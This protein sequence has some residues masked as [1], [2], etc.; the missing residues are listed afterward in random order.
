VL[1]QNRSTPPEAAKNNSFNIAGAVGDDKAGYQ[2]EHGAILDLD[3]WSWITIPTLSSSDVEGRTV[4]AAGKDLFVFGGE[5]WN[6]SQGIVLDQSYLWRLT[7]ADSPASPLGETKRSGSLRWDAAVLEDEDQLLRVEFTGGP[8]GPLQEPCNT[9]YEIDVADTA[10]TVTLTVF[11]LVLAEPVEWPEGTGCDA[12]G[13]F[14]QL[15]AS[16]SEPLGQRTLIDGHDDTERVAIDESVLIRSVRRRR[17]S[18]FGDDQRG[19]RHRRRLPLCRSTHVKLP[20]GIR[21]IK[22]C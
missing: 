16:L 18:L 21:R 11:Q 7:S 13:Y 2:F 9:D 15:Q 10:E 22:S 4:V 1:Q 8:V 20:P 14:W 6:D 5:K 17:I 19:H 3:R 12:V